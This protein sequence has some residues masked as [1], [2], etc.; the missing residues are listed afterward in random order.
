MTGASSE[1]GSKDP[2]AIECGKPHLLDLSDA[3]HGCETCHPPMHAF[4]VHARGGELGGN[5]N[6]D[7]VQGLLKKL[8]C[9]IEVKKA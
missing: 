7:T 5:N 4:C 6:R 2:C 3:A 9:E 8:L 1:D